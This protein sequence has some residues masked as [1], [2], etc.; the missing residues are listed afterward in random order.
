MCDPA[1]SS[2]YTSLCDFYFGYLIGLFP[3]VF[4]PLLLLTFA[5]GSSWASCV[6]LITEIMCED[7]RNLLEG[8][9]PCRTPPAWALWQEASPQWRHMKA[10]LVV[11]SC[12]GVIFSI[13]VEW[14]LKG[15][16][17]R[18]ILNKNQVHSTSRAQTLTKLDLSKKMST[19]SPFLLT[20]S[21]EENSRKSP[22]L[23]VQSLPPYPK[24]KLL[25]KIAAKVPKC[26]KQRC[27][28]C[29]KWSQSLINVIFIQ[30]IQVSII[31]I[32]TNM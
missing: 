12:C 15:A 25:E 23:E 14:K 24:L 18:D 19:K 13:R 3:L 10:S 1:A 8:N 2:V 21:A 7:W 27:C 11:T 4:N 22:N 6:F 17:Y 16:K 26:K 29:F 31:Q 32:S 5:H 9:H 20:G 30:S 28:V